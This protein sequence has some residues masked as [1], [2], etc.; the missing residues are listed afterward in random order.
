MK[1]IGLGLFDLFLNLIFL[2]SVFYADTNASDID[3]IKA[4]YIR[5]KAPD[6]KEMDILNSFRDYMYDRTYFSFY[7][8]L[9]GE[10]HFITDINKF[11]SR[12]DDYYRLWIDHVNGN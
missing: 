1:L 8:R 6:S 12:F 7:I 11:P 9:P 5:F 2:E 10:K 4:S 3:K